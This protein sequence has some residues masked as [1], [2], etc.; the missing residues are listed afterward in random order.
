M[1][2]FFYIFVCLLCNFIT[3]AQTNP[4]KPENQKIY[5]SGGLC[6]TLSNNSSSQQIFSSGINLSFNH[7]SIIN[8]NF[9]FQTGLEYDQTKYFVANFN[10][11]NI[12]SPSYSNMTFNINT[13][14]IPLYFNL[15]LSYQKLFIGAG[16]N[17]SVLPYSK[18]DGYSGQIPVKNITWLVKPIDVGVAAKIGYFFRIFKNEWIIDG[19]VT[20]GLLNLIPKYGTTTIAT[21]HN[22]Y[23]TLSIGYVFKK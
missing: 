15:F 14:T 20:Y 11:N 3:W 16:P 1:I 23:I 19:K 9:M 7:C 13:F 22:N 18:A 21:L 12:P 6:N 10:Y 4:V 8:E 2:R 17:I 5:L